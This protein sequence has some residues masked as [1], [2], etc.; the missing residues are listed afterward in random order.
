MM[1][2]TISTN[3]IVSSYWQKLYFTKFTNLWKKNN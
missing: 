3:I 1:A 2:L